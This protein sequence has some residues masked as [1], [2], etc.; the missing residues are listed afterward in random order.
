MI[1]RQITRVVF[2]GDSTVEQLFTTLVHLVTDNTRDILDNN[3]VVVHNIDNNVRLELHSLDFVNYTDIGEATLAIFGV[4]SQ[5]LQHKHQNQRQEKEQAIVGDGKLKVYNYF[6]EYLQR[7][8]ELKKD[9]EN[10]AEKTNILWFLDQE[11]SNE[12]M[13]DKN[14]V[15][16]NEIAQNILAKIGVSREKS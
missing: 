10:L 4:G 14:M 16:L 5:W 2:V 3:T 6:K 7:V 11:D 8:E 1:G 12:M 9:L 15:V 13:S